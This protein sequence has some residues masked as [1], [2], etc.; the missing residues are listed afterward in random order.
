M[1]QRIKVTVLPSAEHPE[2]LTIEDAMLQIADAFALLKGE[3][4]PGFDWRLVTASTNSPFEAVGEIVALPGAGEAVLATAALATHEAYQGLS[5]VLDGDEPPPVLESALLRRFLARNLNGVGLTKIEP[6]GE[7]Y[8][9]LSVTPSAAAAALVALQAPLPPVSPRRARGTIEGFL[10]DAG[11]YYRQPALKLKERLR[12]RVIWCRI[13]PE[14]EARFAEGTSLRDIWQ[15]SRVRIRGWIE[16]TAHG[17]LAGMTAE[18]ITHVHA[19]EVPDRDLF[20][21]SFTSGLASVD[22]ID[23]LRDGDLG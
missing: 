13:P 20:D 4:G 5:D 7:A 17:K 21:Q 10:V 2:F 11:Q 23:R 19:S 3:G 18:T 22:Y 9:P 6:V 15:N 12:G 1:P 16:Y 8:A 14:L